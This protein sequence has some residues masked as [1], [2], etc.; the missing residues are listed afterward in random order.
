M[1]NT[2]KGLLLEFPGRFGSG[3]TP[4]KPPKELTK[5]LSKAVILDLCATG[6]NNNPMKRRLVSLNE[7][8]DAAGRLGE[9][10]D[11]AAKEKENKKSNDIGDEDDNKAPSSEEAMLFQLQNAKRWSKALED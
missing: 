7:A 11:H 10:K 3:G 8:N 6:A 9:M 5:Q 4:V 2:A 1:R